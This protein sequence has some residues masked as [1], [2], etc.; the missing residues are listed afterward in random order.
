[1]RTVT[2]KS[3][4]VKDFLLDE[5]RSGKYSSGACLPSDNQLTA[6]TGM[7][8]TTVRDAI[9]Q[10][11]SAG[12]MERIQGKGTFVLSTEPERRSTAKS[13]SLFVNDRMTNYEGNPFI[14]EILFGI[15][16]SLMQKGIGVTLTS[17][18]DNETCLDKVVDGEIPGAWSGGVILT[19][20][21]SSKKNIDF[22]LKNNIPCVSIG[23]PLCSAAIPYVDADHFAGGYTAAEHLIELGHRNIAVLDS[24]G[25]SGHYFSAA[26]RRRG[27]EQ[28]LD[29][30]GF[31]ESER[32]FMETR[33]IDDGNISAR[34]KKFFDGD[35]KATAIIVYGHLNFRE[36]IKEAAHRNIEIPKDLSVVYC[37]G[38]QKLYEQFGLI[39]S[40]VIQPLRDMGSAAVEMLLQKTEN[41]ENKIFRAHLSEGTTTCR[42]GK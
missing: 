40:L 20:G 39:T 36:I 1:M 21:Y 32:E 25:D 26:D 28:A 33:E 17:F 5:I 2:L 13:I 23:R 7:S 34:V 42:Q 9:S 3:E 15:H 11:V 35:K 41:G 8:R 18:G 27:I 16:R 4:T 19:S 38:Y 6:L 30:V 29:D 10:L 24:I 12:Y 37:M 31:S 14:E 22:L